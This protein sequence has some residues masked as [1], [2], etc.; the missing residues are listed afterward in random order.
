[1]TINKK[2]CLFY[3]VVALLCLFLAC[4]STNY[5]YDLFAR[6]I[7]GERVIEHGILPFQDFL[8]YTPTNPWYDHEWGSG[9]VFYAL[10]KYI[11]AVGLLIF[12]AIIMFFTAFFV[13][14]T[15][16]L[17]KH[18]YPTSLLFISI[19]LVL[20]MRL[21]SEL[22][23]CQLFSFFF[24]SVFLYI[25]EGT[26]KGKFKNL[27]WTLPL[28][29]IFWN[30]VHGG[31]VSGIGLIAIYLTGALLENKCWV[32]YLG[33]FLCSGLFLII[34]PYGI[35]YLSFLLSAT[36]KHRKYIVEWWP[37]YATRH[38]LYYFPPSLYSFLGFTA[39][40]RTVIK[41]HKIDITKT[42]VLLVTLYMGLAHVKLLSLSVIVAAALCYNDF[43]SLFI[44]WKKI[45]VKIEKSIYA[46]IIIVSLSIPLFSPL[47]PRADLDKFPLY[48]IE[49][50]K[51]NEIKGNIV[52]PFGLG[53]Y[54]SYKLYP[55]NL[56]YMDGR[57]EEVY[58]DKIFMTL[59]NFEI[60]GQNWKDIINNYPTDILMPA[61]TT[62]VYSVLLDDPDWVHIFDGRL[63]GIF[64]KKGTE[65]FSY[66]EPEY[67]IDYYRKTMFK[68]GDFNND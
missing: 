46:V 25:L 68:H 14:K 55:D 26:K 18:A 12:Q 10:I 27:I 15:Q 33:P 19:F 6:L 66:F 32:K 51:I 48:E 3:I 38:I 63:C 53:S 7:V 39:Y 57:Y 50:L 1:M 17:Q 35:K 13:I 45:L 44:K 40:L 30:N 41:K 36:T 23:R 16:R 58:D 47:A 62:S 2:T 8:S 43:V 67:N 64:V 20:Y 24:F 22:I 59:R 60:V 56:I 65:H 28:I 37:F 34:N 9:V 61:K 54:A 52:T 21:N 31:V 29:T 42:I 4:L 11:G 5:D 49:F